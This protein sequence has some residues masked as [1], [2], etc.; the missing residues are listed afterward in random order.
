[1]AIRSSSVIRV[2][3]ELTIDEA[4]K[5]DVTSS[6][7][8]RVPKPLRDSSDQL[9]SPHLVSIGPFHNGKEELKGMEKSKSEAVRRMQ[10]RI[11]RRDR[12]ASVESIVENCIVHTDREIRE[13][14]GE[15]ILYT[16]VQLA[17]MVTRDACFLYEFLV[18]YA[19]LFSSGKVIY[20]EEVASFSWKCDYIFD[21]TYQNPTRERIMDDILL[22]ENQIP[23]WVLQNLL[24]IQMG[25]TG[26]ADQKLDVLMELLLNSANRHKVFMWYNSDSYNR[27]C[28][29]LEVVY[30]GMAG[31]N[32]GSY[33]H[34]GAPE[35]PD[36]P[37]N[38]IQVY[39][40]KWIDSF[41]AIS[42][43]WRNTPSNS[44]HGEA[45]NLELLKL[46]SVVELTQQGVKIRP[47][48]VEEATTWAS[49][50]PALQWIRFDEDTSALYLPQ[51]RVTPQ[52]DLVM[53]S[54]MVM[55]VSTKHRYHP[56][57]ITQFAIFMDDMIDTEEDVTVLTKVDVIR[58][59]LGNDEQVADLFNSMAKGMTP[60]Q[61]CKVIDDVR[62][63]LHRYTRRKY[64]ILW[65]EFVTAYFSKPWLVAGSM[66]AVAQVLREFV[67]G[68][69]SLPWLI[70]VSMAAILLFLL[71]MA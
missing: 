66:A 63:G 25:S 46:P 54:I 3:Y 28:H 37:G 62:R 7:I 56:K 49:A 67:G 59:F 40:R 69:F 22:F 64:K 65:S 18:N 57:P 52:S 53:R 8:F 48:L 44:T 20:Q 61:G 34:N 68:Y 42:S 38:Q 4:D 30:H 19:K 16:P 29:V 27:W 23:L 6:C 31:I 51:P 55:E 39:F 43:R 14:Y 70:A 58:N 45:V 11:Q 5:E 12:F 9:Y 60:I 41:K 1:M 17:W 33:T 36:S 35:L 32:V 24:Q 21:V 47:V 10:K 2:G 13:F 26:A 15:C 50:Y 71:T